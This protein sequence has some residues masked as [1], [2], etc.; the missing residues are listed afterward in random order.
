MG[1]FSAWN[2]FIRIP[3]T[4]IVAGAGLERIFNILDL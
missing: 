3:S 4:G 1:G 2:L